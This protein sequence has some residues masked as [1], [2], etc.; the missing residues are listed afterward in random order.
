LSDETGLRVPRSTAAFLASLQALSNF[1]ESLYDSV[2]VS[3]EPPNTK[4]HG[5]GAQ[6]DRAAEGF[7]VIVVGASMGGVESLTR[8]IERL[9]PN[10]PAAVLVVLHISPEARSYLPEILN[11]AQSLPAAHARDGEAL[12]PGKIYIAPPN[13]HMIVNGRKIILSRGPHENSARPAIDPLFRTAARSFGPRVIGVVLSGGLDDGTLGLM[14]IKSH[15]GL[16][17]VQDPAEAICPSMPESAVRNVRVDYVKP[18]KEIGPLL[19]RL[20]RQPLPLKGGNGAMATQTPKPGSR[21]REPATPAA[22][23]PDIAEFGTD[24]LAGTM[25][26]APPSPFTCPDCGGALWERDSGGVLR[27]RCHIGHGFTADSLVAAQAEKLEEALWIALR[28]LEESAATRRRMAARARSTRLDHI[29][30]GYE[31]GAELAEQHAAVVRDLLVQKPDDSE[32]AVAQPRARR[33]ERQAQQARDRSLPILSKNSSKSRSGR[34][35]SGTK[36]GKTSL[37]PFTGA[38]EEG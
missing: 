6:R 31:Q 22:D 10:L 38:P 18:L 11:R 13:Y 37:V 29:A 19:A 9:P 27:Y 30:H 16:A 25:P 26:P 5:N 20:I 28:A 8:M 36:S 34:A 3:A 1:V 32:S 14:E 21:R 2:P 17:V 12:R 15:G 33:I 7:R 4:A 23:E 24:A 35:K